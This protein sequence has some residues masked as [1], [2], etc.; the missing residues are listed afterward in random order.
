[1]KIGVVCENKLEDKLILNLISKNISKYYKNNVYIDLFIFNNKSSQFE[2][3]FYKSKQWNK[4]IAIEFTLN[5]LKL[6][7][8][9]NYDFLCDISNSFKTFFLSKI[10]LS[11]KNISVS[12]NI[13]DLTLNRKIINPKQHLNLFVKEII[14]GNHTIDYYPKIDFDESKNNDLIKWIFE[15]SSQQSFSKTKFILLYFDVLEKKDEKMISDIIKLVNNT[16]KTKIILIINSDKNNSFKV[17]ENLDEN[18]KRIVIKNFINCEDYV[19]T[20]LILKRCNFLISN[21]KNIIHIYKY[22]SCNNFVEIDK[23]IK[24]FFLN[25]L[26]NDKQNNINENLFSKIS[27][28]LININN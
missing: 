27:K 10:F 17:Y 21:N 12:R 24:P 2:S 28:M 18:L 7:R 11:K 1:M 14:P 5:F 26:K 22:I 20:F 13:F 23:K 16:F 9:T 15:T 4:V 3:V 8:V 6:T 25:V 19:Q